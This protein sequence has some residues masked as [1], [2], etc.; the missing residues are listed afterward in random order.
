MSRALCLI[1]CHLTFIVT[2][3]FCTPHVLA[4]CSVHSI[5]PSVLIKAIHFIINPYPA[6]VENMVSF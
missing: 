2:F 3:V 1:S 5:E 6:N 4:G